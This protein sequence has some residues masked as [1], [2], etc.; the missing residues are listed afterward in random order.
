MNV[1][2][3][4]DKKS[5]V[6]GKLDGGVGTDKY[7]EGQAIYNKFTATEKISVYGTAA[8]DGTTGLGAADNSKIG[9]QSGIS[10][11]SSDG[12]YIVSGGGYDALDNDTYSGSGLP[13]ARNAG[14]HYDSK[15]DK[16]LE[17]INSNYRLG[18]LGVTSVTSNLSQQSL[19]GSVITDN[20]HTNG[21]T[22]FFRQKADGLYT[23][24]PNNTTS[25]RVNVD[26][27]I[28]NNES[29]NN[30]VK[31]SSSSLDGGDN[32]LKY[33]N[34]SN[35]NSKSQEKTVDASVFFSKRFKKP[36]RTFSVSLNGSYDERDAQSFIFQDLYTPTDATPTHHA[37]TDQSKPTNTSA[38]IVSSTITYTEPITKKLSA[39]VSYGI[40]LNNSS[41]DQESYNRLP[42][43]SYDTQPDPDY[44]NNYRFNQFINKAGLN[45]T[46]QSGTKL[47]I[48]FGTRVSDVN[49]KQTDLNQDTTFK[50]DFTNWNP[51]AIIR[52][53]LSPTQTFTFNYSGSNLQ[54]NIS[55]IQPVKNNTD[56]T[57][58]Y[59][60]N[61]DLTAS[62]RQTFFVNYNQYVQVTNSG[63]AARASYSIISDLIIPKR[64]I[65]ANNITTIQ[66][67]NLT[68]KTPYTYNLYVDK[69][70]RGRIFQ[71]SHFY[72]TLNAYGNVNYNYVNDVLDRNSS[73]TYSL[74]A[75]INHVKK[76]KHTIN[77][78][79]APTYTFNKDQFQS[80]F[81]YHT[82]GFSSNDD[83]TIFLTKK[84]QLYTDVDY[85]Y[86]AQ[87][88]SLPARNYTMWN[89]ALS[90]TFLKDD[91]LKLSLSGRNLLNQNYNSI[92]QNGYTINQYTTNS[93]RRYFMLS[94][95]WDF[96]KFGKTAEKK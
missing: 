69:D 41:S 95:S 4:E 34:T 78:S 89:A 27:A 40:D 60:G 59:T 76:N 73:Q 39:V 56:V 55:Q 58:I 62:F 93:I 83:I 9:A 52:Y 68:N 84:L 75:R 79:V 1:I 77:I 94:L 50:R 74:R 72:F 12:G 30:T 28:R 48:N 91:N 54:P 82:P 31:N 71:G 47:L 85:N 18:S 49:F 46:Y 23:Y 16:G 7:Y 24:A 53:T 32:E 5:G 57:T 44:S 19:P 11:I 17:S 70:F 66:Y 37:I 33:T 51:S 25:L 13:V 3:K 35:S 22:Y 65:D 38:A 43:G 90:K 80:S 86:T 61:P 64:T 26:G 96:T 2:L 87:A 63:L 8:N 67:I 42:T 81:N 92:S 88:R 29:Q 14:A 20:T 21:H 36:R 10:V 15:W 6:F 45:F